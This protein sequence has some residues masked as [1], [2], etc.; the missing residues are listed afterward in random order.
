[1]PLKRKYIEDEASDGE[2]HDSRNSGAS[3][4]EY[5]E[6]D[7]FIAPEGSV[8]EAESDVGTKPKKGRRLASGTSEAGKDGD[9]VKVFSN[10]TLD[11][12]KVPPKP[13]NM[14]QAATKSKKKSRHYDFRLTFTNGVLLRKFL[15]PAAHA[16]KKMR[17]VVCKSEAFTGFRIE[18][19]DSGYT[20]ADKGMF[21]CDVDSNMPPGKPCQA[22][23]A[24]FCVNAEAFME[25]LM[26]STLK[27]TDLTLT[28]YMGPDGSESDRIT[29]ECTNN[30]NDVRASYT[31]DL[32]D[33]SQ[34][35]GLLLELVWRRLWALG[36]AHFWPASHTCRPTPSSTLR[37]TWDFT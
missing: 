30:E 18:C 16:V 34:V 32:V 20:L 2:S 33:A 17:F 23:G 10:K 27:E 6:T 11:P 15:E 19:H 26:A 36:A 31:C 22:H 8:S 5:D 28:R 13:A 1:M 4:D 3:D 21:E 35:C 37:L 25:A 12:S 29:F 14:G 9:A 7:S 24:I